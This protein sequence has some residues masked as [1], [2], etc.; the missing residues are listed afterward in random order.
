[1]RYLEAGSG[2]PLVLLHGLLG[3]SFSWRF[4][5]AALS[6]VATL[7]APDALGCG[8]SERD[9]TLDCSVAGAAARVLEF[10]EVLG[11]RGADLLGTSYGGAVAVAAAAQD[12]QR[13]RRIRRLLLVDAVN[14]W[15]A[16][17]RLL[18]PLATRLGWVLPWAVRRFAFTHSYW[19]N[20]QY[21]DPKRVAP[22]TLEGYTLPL[23]VPGTVEH[24][25][26]ILRSWMTDLGC[27]EEQLARVRHLPTLLLW[28][29]ED[30]AVYPSSV[31]ELR[32]RLDEA[33]VVVLP[34]VGHLPYEEAPEGFNRA[35][36]E[37]LLAGSGGARR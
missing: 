6:R 25:R 15:S 31:A 27:Y 1:M 9:A 8:F 34:G 21:A 23:A 5:F 28:G 24:T 26:A 35:V 30:R 32:R 11:L 16:H 3:Y 37:F 13:E 20:R 10:L 17:G 29:A 7:Y 36:T 22:G 4:N 2:P 19:L 33:T 18:I 14:P 12:Q